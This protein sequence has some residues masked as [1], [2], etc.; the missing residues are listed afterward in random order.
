MKTKTYKRI[1]AYVIDWIIIGIIL[2]GLYYFIKDSNIIHELNL[3]LQHINEQL[4]KHQITI[5]TYFKEFSHITYLLDQERSLHIAISILVI[6]I[7]FIIV[8]ILKDGKTIGLYV[9]SLK[10]KGND[11][12]SVFKLFIRNFIVNGL[13]YLIVSFLLSYILKDEAYF[14]S[15]TILGI[16]QIVLALISLFMVIY[17]KDKK[18][19]QD[20]LSNTEI[21]VDK[22]VKE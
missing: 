19:L 13:F 7:Y 20:I 1:M 12:L 5:E 3:N 18:G 8:P 17:K 11:K 9:L 14:I 22:E 15:I 21:I 10:I 4:L 16:I 2:M 6:C